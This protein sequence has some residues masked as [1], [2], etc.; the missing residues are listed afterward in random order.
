[1]SLFF[2]TR[3]LSRLKSWTLFLSLS[4]KFP[5]PLLYNPFPQVT[6]QSSDKILDAL[7]QNRP[8]A[9]SLLQKNLL[10]SHLFSSRL[11]FDC[12]SPELA[13]ILTPSLTSLGNLAWL[14][15]QFS[16]FSASLSSTDAAVLPQPLMSGKRTACTVHRLSL[17]KLSG[18]QAAVPL[19]VRGVA[20]ERRRHTRSQ[21]GAVSQVG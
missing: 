16:R 14:R 10:R 19:T 13:S 17:Q 6:R 8:P 9:I 15:N 3:R 11:F 20:R 7:V 2:T 21:H 18:S 1:M 12:S 4:S 5:A